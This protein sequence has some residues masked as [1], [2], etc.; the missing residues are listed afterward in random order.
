MSFL[1]QILSHINRSFLFF[2]YSKKPKQTKFTGGFS[3]KDVNFTF[4]IKKN[5]IKKLEKSKWKVCVGGIK[6]R[7]DY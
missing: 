7:E 5:K 1:P 3:K 2:F 6:K 4:E